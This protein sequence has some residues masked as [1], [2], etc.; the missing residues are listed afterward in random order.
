MET[1]QVEGY[2]TTLRYKSETQSGKAGVLKLND[3]DEPYFFYSD[4]LMD[5]AGVQVG[6]LVQLTLA[7]NV[8][9]KVV[10]IQESSGKQRTL[11]DKQQDAQA[12]TPAKPA[13]AKPSEFRTPEQIIRTEACSMVLE[14]VALLD[15]MNKDV[16][17][18][19]WSI[20]QEIA[21][22]ITYGKVPERKDPEKPAKAKKQEAKHEIHD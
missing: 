16:N 10:K 19:F 4:D 7:G 18:N 3:K 8:V 21:E 6:C 14:H 9:K 2:V 12:F 15:V 13:Q 17:P 1:R 20:V 11:E 22:Y 5:E